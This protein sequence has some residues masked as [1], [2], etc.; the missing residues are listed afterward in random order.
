MEIETVG[1]LQILRQR[2]PTLPV[3]PENGLITFRRLYLHRLQ[4]GQE[5]GTVLMDWA[6]DCDALDEAALRAQYG[7]P[8]SPLAFFQV[9]MERLLS[10]GSLGPSL[11]VKGRTVQ[12]LLLPGH[13]KTGFDALFVSQIKSPE[14]LQDAPSQPPSKVWYRPR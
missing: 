9:Y 14:P 12:E 3:D 6:I 10:E 4:R 7:V 11:K 2:Q 8:E 13:P 1:V 5:H